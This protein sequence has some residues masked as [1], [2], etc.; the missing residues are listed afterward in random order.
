[1]PTLQASPPGVNGA[2]HP[3]GGHTISCNS[4]LPCAMAP[5]TACSSHTSSTCKH[6]LQAYLASIP[7]QLLEQVLLMVG[8]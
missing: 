4:A 2:G 3:H 8:D 7:C 6:T 5:P 1:M